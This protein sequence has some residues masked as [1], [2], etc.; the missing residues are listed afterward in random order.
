MLHLLRIHQG[1]G[2]AC[3]EPDIWGGLRPSLRRHGSRGAAGVA[4]DLAGPDRRRR[5]SVLCNL[6][7]VLITENYG[8]VIDYLD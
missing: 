8:R 2:E 7:D 6:M 1:R 5:R 3:A 4:Q